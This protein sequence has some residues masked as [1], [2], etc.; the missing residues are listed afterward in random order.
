MIVLD[1]GGLL[2]AIDTDSRDH[3]AA[4]R[5]LE[6]ERGP[7]LLTSL[8]LAEADYMIT[9]RIGQPAEEQF[10]AD[11]TDGAYELVNLEPADV[12]TCLTVIQR[13]RALNIGLADASVVLVAAKYRT[14]R[15]LSFSY[16]HFRAI[17]P[18]WG[19]HFTLLP[20]DGP[21]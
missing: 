17:K 4:R 20:A 9:T 6:G 18:L 3:R 8:A 14:T 2:A 19:E 7:L 5:V 11:V 12:G 16:R 15:L 21:G 1:T 13:Y 10:L